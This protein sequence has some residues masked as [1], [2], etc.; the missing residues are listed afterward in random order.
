MKH[1]VIQR[2]RIVRSEMEIAARNAAA[3]AALAAT[4]AEDNP[5]KGAGEKRDALLQEERELELQAEGEALNGKLEQLRRL[6]D[7]LAQAQ[8]A[9]TLADEAARAA[10]EHDSVKRWI[11]A[12]SLARQVGVGYDFAG[13]FSAW[14]LSGKERFAGAPSCVSYFC[15]N[16]QTHPGLRFDEKNDRSA[17]IKWHLAK[18]ES[19][20][21]L[22]HWDALAQQ[23]AL[24][25]R[26]NPE[27][28][29]V[30]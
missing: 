10:S 8:Q 17:I 26:E 13:V 16:P 22:V 28:V 3:E 30:A 27:L 2:L 18:G 25:L 23:R 21:A 29:S 15:S 7:E 5:W 11:R 20:N 4:G 14:Y 19:Q 24:L 1:E 6:D 9:R 12:G